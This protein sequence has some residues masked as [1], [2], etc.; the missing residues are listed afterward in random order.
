MYGRITEHR[1]Y[2][3]MCNILVADFVFWEIVVSNW[4]FENWSHMWLYGA[5][6]HL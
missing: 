5:R 6:T 2:I 1:G 4:Y 3:F